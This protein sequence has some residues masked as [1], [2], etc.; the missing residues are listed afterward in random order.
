MNLACCGSNSSTGL[1][2]VEHLLLPLQFRSFDG[3]FQ[4]RCLQSAS[5][6]GRHRHN[7]SHLQIAG[8]DS[9]EPVKVYAGKIDLRLVSVLFGVKGS[10][11]AA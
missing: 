5:T 10:F 8:A 7:P 6:T 1:Q 3:R 11:R 9:F 4:L 2:S